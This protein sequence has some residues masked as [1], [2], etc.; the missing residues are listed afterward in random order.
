MG[1]ETSYLGI[2][3]DRWGGGRDQGPWGLVGAGDKR[4]NITAF[5]SRDRVEVPRGHTSPV[6]RPLGL[7]CVSSAAGPHQ[8]SRGG[9][10]APGY[11]LT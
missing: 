1:A 6:L 7:L 3:E 4:V 10:G 5:S 8:E 2:A 11:L 9:E